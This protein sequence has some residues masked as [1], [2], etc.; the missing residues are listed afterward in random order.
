MDRVAAVRG[1]PRSVSTRACITLAAWADASVAA[2]GDCVTVEGCATTGDRAFLAREGARFVLSRGAFGGRPMY[3]ARPSDDVLIA[4]SRLEPLLNAVCLWG[5]PEPDGARVCAFVAVR[6]PED[7]TATFFRG[8][9][10]LKSG[11]TIKFRQGALVRSRSLMQTPRA[12]QKVERIEVAA[13]TVRDLLLRSVENVFAAYPKVGILTGGGTDSSALL[14]CAVAAA[15]GADAR[16][17]EALAL[18]FA[19]PGDDRPHLEALCSALGIVPLRLPSAVGATLIREELVADAAPYATTPAGWPLAMLRLARSRGLD[20]VVTGFLAEELFDAPVRAL[21]GEVLSHPFAVARILRGLTGPGAGTTRRRARDVVFAPL[22]PFLTPLDSIRA[23]RSRQ[24]RA[25][26]HPWAGER[27]REFLASR[28]T[29][30]RTGE[31]RGIVSSAKRIRALAGA[32]YL[33]DI[34]DAIGQLEGLSDCPYLTPFADEELAQFL[35]RVPARLFF[36]GGLTRGLL[37][38]AMRGL[39]PDTVRLRKDRASFGPAFKEALRAAGGGESFRDL[40]DVTHLSAMKVVD[41]ARFRR[42][43]EEFVAQ[44]GTTDFDW[45][46]I[47]PVLAAE[48]HAR[49]YAGFRS[50]AVGE[51]AGCALKQ[52]EVISSGGSLQ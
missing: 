32:A 5:S 34:R 2:D 40:A 37:R 45:M 25:A 1:S 39:V 22:R 17:V 52:C 41:A 48:A 33:T 15:R 18:Y 9:N 50:R 42:R 28:S 21:A 20:A 27:L 3:Y 36:H 8:V 14:A 6:S 23:R 38:E 4:C 31:L 10:R 12:A 11:E 13:R 47:W 30:G 29:D 16:Q 43:Y 51:G 35:S 24:Q 7:A 46:E 49:W 26:S 19:G 44:P